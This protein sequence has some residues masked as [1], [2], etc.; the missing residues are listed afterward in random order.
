MT[1]RVQDSGRVSFTL[2]TVKRSLGNAHL[3]IMLMLAGSKKGCKQ[4][5]C[6]HSELA[7]KSIAAT[8]CV[9]I[10]VATYEPK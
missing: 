1:Q 8:Y 9:H 6:C 3:A 5:E 10:A 4:H 7:L 2:T